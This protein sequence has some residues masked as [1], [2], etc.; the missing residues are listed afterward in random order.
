M[1]DNSSIS[2]VESKIKQYADTRTE[3]IP[4]KMGGYFYKSVYKFNNSEGSEGYYC[5]YRAKELDR[6]CFIFIFMYFIGS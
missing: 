6:Y 3:E 5:L 1:F 2:Q 4:D